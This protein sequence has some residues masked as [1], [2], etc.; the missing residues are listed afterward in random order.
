M[1]VMT[2]RPNKPKIE[3]LEAAEPIEA[4][5]GLQRGFLANKRAD[6]DGPPFFR[7]GRRTVR[8]RRSAVLAWVAE[9]QCAPPRQTSGVT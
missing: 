7:L 4:A 3:P 9:C 1:R 2:K 5:L 8:Y 6:G